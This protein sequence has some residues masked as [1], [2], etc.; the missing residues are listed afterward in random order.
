MKRWWVKRKTF[1]SFGI[2]DDFAKEKGLKV[3]EIKDNAT[4]V[5]ELNDGSIVEANMYSGE[6]DGMAMLDPNIT[7]AVII[8]GGESHLTMGTGT[9]STLSITDED[10][11]IL[12]DYS[13]VLSCSYTGQTT[14]Y[15]VT[16]NGNILTAHN[17]TE[18]FHNVIATVTIP[19]GISSSINIRVKFSYTIEQPLDERL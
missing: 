19:G 1:A 15:Y 18:L 13:V 12:S 10:G 14:T 11:N 16:K 9:T 5:Y 3:K 6:S 7:G 8:N 4:V 17:P 2:S